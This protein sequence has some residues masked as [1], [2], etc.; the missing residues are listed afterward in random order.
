VVPVDLSI[1]QERDMKGR[2]GLGALAL[3]AVMG[4]GGV[5][6]AADTFKVDPVHSTVIF[7][8]FHFNVAPFYGRFDAPEGTFVLDDAD[9]AKSTFEFSIPVEKVDTGNEK[10]DNHLK[11]PDFFN[12]KQFPAIT[13]KSTAVKKRADQGYEVTGDLTIHGV[14]KSVTINVDKTGQA[15]DPMGK[16]RAGLAATFTVRRSDYG[17][18]FMPQGLGDDVV[19]MVGIEGLKQ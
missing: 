14:T 15:K 17:V 4:F 5:V 2:F 16:E 8:I 1:F 6:R 19:L 7:K 10:R 12:A 18:S 9:A 3:A 13:F 11:G